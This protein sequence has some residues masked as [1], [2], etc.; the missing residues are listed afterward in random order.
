MALQ[1]KIIKSKI[2][3]VQ[4][5]RKI[6]KAMELV[7]VAKMRKAVARTLSTRLY[8][9][10][11]LEILIALSKDSS[12]RHPLLTS[13]D[14]P[15]TLFVMISANKGLCGSFN[16]HNNKKVQ[17][18]I[19]KYGGKEKHTF[20]TVGKYAERY[21]SSIGAESIAS[22][23]E[24][25]ESPTFEDIRALS[26]VILDEFMGGKYDKV[27]ISYSHYISALSTLPVIRQLL[28]VTRDGVERMITELDEIDNSVTDISR[29][30][31]S[32]Y[33]YEPGE[34]VLLNALL[35]RLTEARVYQAVVESYASEHS[36]RMFAMKNATENADNLK[37][38]LTL[39]YNKARQEGITNEISEIA[40]G[41]EALSG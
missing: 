6:T 17:Y 2:A 18:S 38:K 5:I 4:N 10:K 19:S 35:P 21:I 30:S 32:N 3:S 27:M 23:I 14:A 1:T 15:K 36:S 26:R 22:F 20:I 8:A 40:S 25:P 24:I 28:P 13:P 39:S 29:K 16:V 37:E 11:A 31:F 7:S 34:E 33:V 12:F 9:T 41:A